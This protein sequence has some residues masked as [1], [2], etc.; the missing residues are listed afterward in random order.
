MTVEKRERGEKHL[1]EEENETATILLFKPVYVFDVSQTKGAELPSVIHATGDAAVYL[2]ALEQA[3]RTAGIALVAVPAIVEIPGA[4]GVSLGSH[5]RIRADLEEADRFR[6]L[7]HEF[8]HELLH[9]Q[10]GLEDRAVRET[11]ADATAFVVCRHFGVRC[12]TADYLL[13]H[14]SN[15]KFFLERLETIRRTAVRH[16]EAIE[17]TESEESAEA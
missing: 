15:A 12:D 1:A 3:I 17:C 7:A 13:L 4:L 11:E 2:P 8:A 5:I 10:E 6:T 9:R 16:I 14:D